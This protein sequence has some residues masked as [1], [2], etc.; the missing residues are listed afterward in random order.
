MRPTIAK[1]PKADAAPATKIN[2]SHEAADSAP[3]LFPSLIL[4]QPQSITLFLS[5]SLGF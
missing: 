3:R 2:K 5:I 1:N 4:V